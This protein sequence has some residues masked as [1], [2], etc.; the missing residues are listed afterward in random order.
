M[1]PFDSEILSYINQYTHQSE[2]FDSLMVTVMNSGL[3][4]GG[5]AMA[6]LW[7]MWFSRK[8]EGSLRRQVV[9]ISLFASFSAVFVS[10]VVEHVLP[11]RPRPIIDPQLHFQVAYG[12][13]LVG[14]VKWLHSCFPSDHA[15][16]FFA[17]AFAF[18]LVSWRLGL[19]ASLYVFLIIAFPRV[20]NGLHYPTDIVAG[21]FIA[22]CAVFLVSIPLLRQRL[23]SPLLVF[24]ERR[25]GWFYPLF[26]VLCYQVS[27]LF[28]DVRAFGHLVLTAFKP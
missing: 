8:R 1:I 19:L 7:W 17:I 25:P 9:L 26:F 24:A 20:Y 12:M 16:L 22:A 28:S 11:P 15:A 2:N 6:A 3:L 27:V 13:N 10:K 14:E 4:K 23:T 21:A 18:F 5:T